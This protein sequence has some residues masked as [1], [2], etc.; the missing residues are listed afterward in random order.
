MIA[1]DGRTVNE[2][3]KDLA[4]KYVTAHQTL[5]DAHERHDRAEREWKEAI[6]VRNKIATELIA[7][8]GANVTDRHIVVDVR[9]NDKLVVVDRN[10]VSMKELVK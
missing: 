10:G 6:E 7:T 5:A 8:I 2:K 1:Y 4:L 9:G 3:L